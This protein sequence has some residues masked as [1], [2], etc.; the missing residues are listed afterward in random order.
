MLENLS[1]R[2]Q[3]VIKTL[4]GQARLTEDNIA[5]A[6]REVRM[7]LLEA[8]VAL[9]VVK[10]FIAQV[11][12]RAQG[13]EVL[14]SLTPGQAVIEVVHQELTKL[15]GAEAITKAE[16]KWLSRDVLEATHETGDIGFVSFVS[17]VLW[18]TFCVGTSGQPHCHPLGDIF[19]HTFGLNGD[20]LASPV[21]SRNVGSPAFDELPA[22][23]CVVANGCHRFCT[24]ALEPHGARTVGGFDEHAEMAMVVARVGL[25]LDAAPVSV[26][27]HAP[28]R[29][30]I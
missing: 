29:R 20:C 11:K 28:Q 26:A 13:K 25:A 23:V 3:G 18:T 4:R 10:D 24:S 21:A 1:G 5:D 7:A 2:L 14:A 22:V 27:N 8:D 30:S 9:P 15:M 16:L 6:M 19:G 12:E 17:F